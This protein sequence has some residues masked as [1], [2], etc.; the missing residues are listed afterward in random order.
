MKCSTLLIIQLFLFAQINAQNTVG[1]IKSKNPTEG[2]NLLYPHNQ[3]N[4]YIINN[5]GEIV[6]TWEDE[7]NYKP[8]NMAYLL[9]NGNLYKTK[10]PKDFSE[11]TFGAGGAGGYIELRTWDNELLWST[12]FIDSTYRAHHDIAPLPNG[13]V[14]IIIWERKFI[15]EIIQA[16]GDTSTTVNTELWPDF[17]VEMDPVR[18]S[19]VW[20]WHTWDHLIQ[21]FDA[22]KDNYGVVEDHPELVDINYDLR[23]FGLKPDWMHVNSI[24]YDPINDHILLSVPNFS[25]VWIID[26]STT[27]EEAKSHEGGN[28]GKGGDLLFRW[29]NPESYRAGTINDKKLFYEHD[30]RWNDDFISPNNERFGSI[31]IFNNRIGSDYSAVVGISPIWNET[32]QQ[33]EFRDGRF[34]PEDYDY[35]LT[36]PTPTKMYSNGLSGAQLLDNGNFFITVGRTGYTFEITPSDEIIWEHITPLRGGVAVSQGES[37]GNNDNQT[38]RMNKYPLDYSAFDGRDLSPKGFIELNPVALDNCNMTTSSIEPTSTSQVLIEIIPNPATNYLNFRVF[39]QPKIKVQIYNAMGI[40]K[41]LIE[42]S[43]YDKL[44]VSDWESG[45]YFITD[46]TGKVLDKVLI[47][48]H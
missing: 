1:L 39:G 30:A 14:L 12:S 36:H 24:D 5:C 7:A 18:D 29:G 10:G 27:T 46:D 31:S 32:D 23:E 6:H 35:L 45:L 25:E 11:S 37:L 38:F 44:A 20:E 28:S 43:D 33:Y 42:V 34:W 21:D 3:S 4:V 40:R 26:H 16:G 48:S 19:I 13:N 47:N 2:Y 15:D 9:P 22:T 17:I 41:S 8:G